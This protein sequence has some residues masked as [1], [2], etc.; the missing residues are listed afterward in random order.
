MRG[1]LVVRVDAYFAGTAFPDQTV[2]DI[3]L[4]IWP[5]SEV[6]CR[7]LA[8]HPALAARAISVLELGAGKPWRTFVFDSISSSPRG[9]VML[10]PVHLSDC[11]DLFEVFDVPIQVWAS[12]ACLQPS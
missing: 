4:D 3:G 10:V 1:V 5:A 8:S 9:H 11:Q 6:L 12:Q 2:D 7:F